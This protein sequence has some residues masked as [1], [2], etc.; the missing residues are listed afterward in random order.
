MRLLVAGSQGQVARAVSRWSGEDIVVEAF[1]RPDLDL[2][3]PVTIARAIEAFRPDVVVNAAAYTAV[4]RAE[5][6]AKEA[7]AV[8]RDGAHN[9]ARAAFSACCPVIH[10]STD[11]V[12]DGRLGRPYCETDEPA[13][14]NVYGASKLA[15][16]L[17]VAEA[18]PAH[19]I[20]RCSWVFS[21]DGSNFLNTMLRLA[22]ERETIDVVADQFGSPTSAEEVA[23]AVVAVAKRMVASHE[24]HGWRGTFHAVA[25]HYT[26]WAAFADD[27]FRC[28]AAFGGPSAKIRPTASADY[29]VRAL[30]PSDTRL[31]PS[32][33]EV[34]FGLRLADY[35]IGMDR[36]VLA[37]TAQRAA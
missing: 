17:A 28:S 21:S 4:D 23:R 35:R 16:E 33:F 14:I 1:G 36:A 22:K 11:Y 32:Q 26:N 10:L 30:R 15:G 25:P 8:N 19:A 18:N 24:D 2:L 13:P 7:F 27:I 9:I 12:F 29:P 34:A 20:L 37:M 6:E 31:D 5:D 3:D